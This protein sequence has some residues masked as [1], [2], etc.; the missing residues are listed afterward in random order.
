MG[1]TS[2]MKNDVARVKTTAFPVT[3]TID[4]LELDDDDDYLNWTASGMLAEGREKI[5]AELV[6][7]KTIGA[8]AIV[9]EKSPAL[10]EVNSPSTSTLNQKNAGIDGS[11]IAEKSISSTSLATPLPA[12]TDK[13]AIVNQKLASISD[14]GAQPNYSNASL[15]IFSTREKVALPKEPN[16]TSPNIPYQQ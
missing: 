4:F 1:A 13:Q 9:V 5:V 6:E 7:R 16:G 10:S 15:Q 8:E 11:V 12:M 14:E 3:S 2:S